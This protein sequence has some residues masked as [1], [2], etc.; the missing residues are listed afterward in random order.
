[1]YR[2][3]VLA[4]YILT[5]QLVPRQQL[6]GPNQN[7]VVSHSIWRQ[8]WRRSGYV[9][10]TVR[11]GILSS[12]RQKQEIYPNLTQTFSLSNPT[13]KMFHLCWS[14]DNE[15]STNFLLYSNKKRSFEVLCARFDWVVCVFA[16]KTKLTRTYYSW[17]TFLR[18]FK[19]VRNCSRDGR[20]EFLLV[21]WASTNRQ[22]SVVLL[23][24]LS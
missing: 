5:G 6:L 17:E 18:T 11:Q 15:L 20:Q 10:F 13:Q 7:K 23:D 9:F 2:N 14:K 12:F 8:R 16:L 24:S 4:A 19:G 1:M 22:T 21:S 3:N